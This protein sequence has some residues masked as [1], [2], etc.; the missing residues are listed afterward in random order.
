MIRLQCAESRES[1]LGLHTVLGDSG[2]QL[3]ARGPC[4]VLTGFSRSCGAKMVIKV[5][6]ATVAGST[7]IKKK[8]QDVVGFLEANRID[9][10][11]KDIACNDDNRKWM[12]D[13]VP[14][15]KK[16]KN[17][18]PLPPQIFNEEQYC[19]DFESF[20]DAKEGN[21]IFIFLGLTAPKPAKSET[22]AVEP[23]ENQEVITNTEDENPAGAE[24][25]T[26]AAAE[27]ETLQITVGGSSNRGTAVNQRSRQDY[28]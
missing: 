25:E 5:F 28:A 12:R 26:A 21:E 14:G 1:R 18:I 24:E 19:G 17:G 11:Q 22:S 9:F 3:H 23:A 20:F 16:P 4:Y 7:A 8:Q 2:C 6:V 13:N 15:E 10:E 27:E